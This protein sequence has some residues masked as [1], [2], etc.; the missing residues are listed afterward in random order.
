[1][2]G[3]RIFFKMLIF[4]LKKFRRP[5]GGDRLITQCFFIKNYQI[6]QSFCGRNFLHHAT[7]S[8]IHL[9]TLLSSVEIA[10]SD[11]WDWTFP[12]L[13]H[14]K[15]LKNFRRASRA[16]LYLVAKH[17]WFSR[18]RG[19]WPTGTY[20]SVSPGLRPPPRFGEIRS[21]DIQNLGFLVI[22][23][24]IYKGKSRR[25]RENFAILEVPKQRFLRGKRSKKGS[26]NG[27]NR[28]VH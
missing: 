25:R 11:A 20:F 15:K 4:P 19:W 6:T 13:W 22:L 28:G 7:F 17:F 18:A 21:W 5:S 3:C 1:M 10:H 23:G 8:P 27:Q 24:D 12:T 2:T 14:S 26:Q 16:V 9:A